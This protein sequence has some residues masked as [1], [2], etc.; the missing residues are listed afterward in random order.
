MTSLRT[1]AAIVVVLTFSAGEI[2]S[3]GEGPLTATASASAVPVN[4]LVSLDGVLSAAFVDAA[5]DGYCVACQGGPGHV[6]GS[7]PPECP[8]CHQQDAS[9]GDGWHSSSCMGANNCTNHNCLE[10]DDFDDDEV[11]NSE[12]LATL[13][14][15]LMAQDAHAIADL[16]RAHSTQLELSRDRSALQV[17][18]CDGMVIAHYPVSTKLL[19][20]LMAL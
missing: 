17:F 14:Q 16:L 1:T 13:G 4:S 18:A 15:S 5:C 3:T 12:L 7:T 11:A 10:S 8:E 20:S 19:E 6:A 9:A 2:T